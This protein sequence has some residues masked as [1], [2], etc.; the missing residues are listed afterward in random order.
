LWIT[1][2]AAA[3]AVLSEEPDDLAAGV[4]GASDELLEELLD[5]SLEE[6]ASFVAVLDVEESLF[7]VLAAGF[8]EPLPELR[9][10]VR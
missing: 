9:L 6:P 7:S 1:Q 10:S 5:E 4:L 3:L 2:L 8:F